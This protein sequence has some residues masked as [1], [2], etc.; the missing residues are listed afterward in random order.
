MTVFCTEIS[1]VLYLY[2]VSIRELEELHKVGKKQKLVEFVN[3]MLCDFACNVR[4]QRK[5]ETESH[6]KFGI[7]D[8]DDFCTP[9]KKI[10]KPGFHDEALYSRLHYLR[11]GVDRWS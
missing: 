7:N 11:G 9:A 1:T 5:L 4:R 8:R 3:M 10:I 2:D 6:N